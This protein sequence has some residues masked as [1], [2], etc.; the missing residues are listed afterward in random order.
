MDLLEQDAKTF[1]R[2]LPRDR[3]RQSATVES[4]ESPIRWSKIW[5]PLILA[6]LGWAA[7]WVDLPVARWCLRHECPDPLDKWLK[8]CEAFAHGFGVATILI[9]VATL[10]PLRRRCVPRLVAA[11]FGAGLFA[12][13][14]KLAL[15][16]VRP[17]SFSFAGGVA[18]TFSQWFPLAGAGS[19]L[20]GFPSAHTATAVGLA[21]ALAWQYPRGRWLFLALAIS[22]SA[23]RVISGDHFVSD[24]VWGA[25]LGA[26]CAAGFLDGGLLSPWFDRLE[27]WIATP[28]KPT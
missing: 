15:A 3:D 17:H 18:D 23:Q 22:A 2:S 11:S 9:T 21:L 26:F 7:L 1:H 8:L 19:D 5:L 16:R 14:F 27:R 24:A 6:I 13:L 12:N 20:Q 4:T 25:A 28:A 10:D